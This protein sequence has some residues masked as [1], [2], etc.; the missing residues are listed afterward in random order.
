MI[1]APTNARRVSWV[2]AGF[3]SATR[4]N[5][6][7]MRL[8]KSYLLTSGLVTELHQEIL[9]ESLMFGPH[10]GNFKLRAKVGV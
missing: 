3:A 7:A 10:D 4:K 9:F 8:N 6:I 1:R 2:S 5:K